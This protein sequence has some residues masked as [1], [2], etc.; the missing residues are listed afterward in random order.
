MKVTEDDRRRIIKAVAAAEVHT[1]G[2]ISCV[3]APSVSDFRETPMIW[4]AIAALVLPAAALFL[5]FR[6]EPLTALMG[7]WTVGHGAAEQA[8]LF[9]TLIAYVAL[10]A[11]VF[12]AVAVLVAVPAVRRA[13]TS[14][15]RKAE[16]VHKAA[17]TQFQTMG[18]GNTRDHTGVLIFAAFAERRA[19]VIADEGIFNKTQQVVWDEVVDGLLAG[20]KRGEVGD[21][22]VAAVTRA[23]EILA[24]HVPPDADNPNETPDD[25]R[26]VGQKQRR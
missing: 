3:I 23:G 5:G 22:F 26:V 8:T 12:V 2:E 15:A 9:T 25:L 11:A 14:D 21:G 18:L 7:G 13:L 10:Q 1:A 24:Q 19:E 17:M 6:P 4:A 16:L 20:L